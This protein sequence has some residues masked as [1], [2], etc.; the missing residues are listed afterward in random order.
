MAA[1]LGGPSSQEMLVP[2]ALAESSEGWGFRKGGSSKDRHQSW[3]SRG[4][5]GY[6][7]SQ[8]SEALLVQVSP[9][10]QGSITWE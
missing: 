4:R 6:R 1:T 5:Q 10:G 7:G 8:A 9:H 2:N 3:Q